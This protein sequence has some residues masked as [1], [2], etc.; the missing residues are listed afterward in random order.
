MSSHSNII[1]AME[2]LKDTSLE[3]DNLKIQNQTY[4]IHLRELQMK[5]KINESQQVEINSLKLQNAS[6]IQMLNDINKKKAYWDEIDPSSIDIE[7]YFSYEYH[8][9]WT[10]EEK[11]EYIN[12]L[13]H[14]M[15]IKNLCKK[16]Q[17]NVITITRKT[18]NSSYETDAH[19]RHFNIKVSDDR[20]T[21]HVYLSKKPDTSYFRISRITCEE[22]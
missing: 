11:S 21:H 1:K 8:S 14:S 19:D 20:S 13:N 9:L 10:E 22:F 17:S 15:K 12:W 7:V 18:H 6:L 4:Q 3:M 2:L 5:L 16:Y